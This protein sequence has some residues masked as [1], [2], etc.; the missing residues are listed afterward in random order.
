[1][2]LG[3]PANDLTQPNM[4]GRGLPP[5][6]VAPVPMQR[7]PSLGAAPVGSLGDIAPTPLPRP[8]TPAPKPSPTPAAPNPSGSIRPDKPELVRMPSGN[9][10]AVGT[11]PGSNPGSMVVISKG[12]NGEGVSTLVS[13]GMFNPVKEMGKNTIAGSMMGQI[14][15]DVATKAL[16]TTKKTV[17]DAANTAGNA[18]SQAVGTVTKAAGDTFNNVMGGLGNLGNAFGFGNS[19]PTPKPVNASGSPDDRGTIPKLQPQY[20]TVTNPAYTAWL[21]SQGTGGA[22]Q[23]LQDIHDARDSAMVAATQSAPRPLTPAPP[24]TIRVPVTPAKQ[25]G[26]GGG[27][28]NNNGGGGGGQSQP[29]TLKGTATGKSYT[30]GALYSNN[31]GTFKAVANP[32]GTAKFV[33]VS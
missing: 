32:D 4:L 21:A 16:D 24:Q 6:A 27:G 20:K 28:G 29:Q 22:N 18:T 5:S 9:L 8:I 11:Y 7:P 13:P 31:N 17:S 1:M 19:T 25:G 30:A 33:K 10:V 26:N 2:A 23:T 3:Q 14:A 12:P 15:G